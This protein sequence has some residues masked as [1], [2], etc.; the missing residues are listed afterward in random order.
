MFIRVV[1]SKSKTGYRHKTV[2]I[3]ESYRE[4]KKVKTRLL[5]HLGPLHK[6]LDKD[7]DKLVDSL[8]KLKGEVITDKVKQYG[9]AK[10]LGDMFG[11]LSLLQELKLL[12]K[13]R[14]LQ[15]S[16]SKIEFDVAS[17][18]NALISGR[19]SDPCSKLKLLTWLETVYLPEVKGK[20]INYNNLLRTMDFII[21]HKSDI[22]GHLAKS[23]MT[24]F[25]VE[26]NIC[27]Y[28]ITS[29]Y[30]ETS[31]IAEED[32]RRYD[33]SR[34][35]RRDR[36][37]VLIGVVMTEE[38]IPIAHYV[39][40][41]NTADRSTLEE[42]MSDIK[43]RFGSH[44]NIT[45]VTDKGM[46]SRNNLDW[47][48]SQGFT[49]II[50]ESRNI[51]LNAKETIEE[52]NKKYQDKT[53]Q[54]TFEKE[55]SYN[56]K[57]TSNGGIISG[58][59][60]TSIRYI[61][62]FNPDTYKLNME[63]F[64]TRISRFDESVKEINSKRILVNDKYSQ[65][66]SH[67]ANK[68]IKSLYDIT[69]EKDNVCIRQRKDKFDYMEKSF[70]WFVVKSNLNRLEYDSEKIISTY[71]ELW[72]VEHSFRELK[73]SLDV[74]PVYHFSKRRIRS[75][76]FICYLALV[77][78]SIAERK[79]KDNNINLSW[80]RAFYELKKT[81]LINYTTTTNIKSVAVTASTDMAK[82]IFKAL[83]TFPPTYKKIVG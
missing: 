40:P 69:I 27:F 37:Q 48:L 47:L 67:A 9:S 18:L 26:L 10:D 80:E 55:Y 25:D 77:T 32:I 58:K 70:G 73:H 49:F 3:V 12:Q 43:N 35:H 28:D 41:G 2:Q 5:L 4:G 61:A 71:K 8:L 53:V 7:V 22:E 33:Y 17:N 30:F 11:I 44:L 78:T 20:D 24:I 76:I 42:V 19:I 13:V 6:V 79:L 50:G 34:D 83:G 72:R 46:I 63:K 52:A 14:K 21:S 56:Y 51:S 75:H 60:S 39:F 74:R 1:N 31:N 16:N 23:V 54:H 68:H 57:I 15:G 64:K 29:T 82:K 45:P 81:K 62:S 36:C 59:G 65:I 38:G 66:N